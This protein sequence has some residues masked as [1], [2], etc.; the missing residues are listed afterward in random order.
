MKNPKRLLHYFI[1]AGLMLSTGLGWSWP[2]GILFIYWLIPAFYTGEI[3]LIDSVKR[4]DRPPH[5]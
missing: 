2:W 4:D 5:P 3:Q 1:F